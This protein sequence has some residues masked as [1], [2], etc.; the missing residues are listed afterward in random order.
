M[1]ITDHAPVVRLDLAAGPDP[2][3]DAAAAQTWVVDGS[4]TVLEALGRLAAEGGDERRAVTVVVRTPDLAGAPAPRRAA[5]EAA[6]EALRGIVQ[7]ATL[8]DSTAGLRVNLVA[9]GPDD[10]EDV[11][12]TV[13]FLS[14]P[15]AGFVIGASF[16][17]RSAR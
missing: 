2:G 3:G 12:R 6:V 17:L 15:D 4:V 14:S 11:A 13:A 8:E 16:D 7:S 1:S 10:D 9:G 5:A